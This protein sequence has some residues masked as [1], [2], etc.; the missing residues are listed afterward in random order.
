[1]SR[2]RDTVDITV[3]LRPS[4][5]AAHRKARR[6]NATL[7]T[8]V[9]ASS[10][11]ESTSHQGPLTTA[12]AIESQSILP[13]TQFASASTGNGSFLTIRMQHQGNQ[14][15]RQRLSSA[16]GKSDMPSSL[17]LA[18]DYSSYPKQSPLSTSPSPPSSSSIRQQ[19]HLNT[20]A[21][22]PCA[23]GVG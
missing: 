5:T 4:S 10:A 16:P 20:F 11:V 1:M 2:F 7:P 17:Q 18:V 22:T 9:A 19:R 23:V 3:A 6:C 15:T 21:S 14:W 8:P 12:A 13:A